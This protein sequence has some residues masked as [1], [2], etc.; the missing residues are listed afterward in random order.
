MRLAPPVAVAA[1]DL[2]ARAPAGRALARAEGEPGPGLVVEPRQ[3][4]GTSLLRVRTRSC[5][6]GLC[7]YKTL[8]SSCP[9]DH[10][11]HAGKT[12]SRC[13]D[14]PIPFPS[15]PVKVI[16]CGLLRIRLFD[17]FWGC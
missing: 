8:R 15:F 5:S 14:E 2:T 3:G 12:T 17:L 16:R 6:S 1:P 7:L 10:A 11:A 9:P 4:M 13:K